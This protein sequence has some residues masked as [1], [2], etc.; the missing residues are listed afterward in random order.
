MKSMIGLAGALAA[1]TF[2]VPVLAQTA[3]WDTGSSRLHATRAQLE[4]AVRAAEQAG[5]QEA[6]LIRTRLQE[7]DFRVG[8]QI[9]LGVTGQQSLTGDFLVLEGPELVLPEIGTI[10]LAGLLR[11]ELQDALRAEISKFV[12]DPQVVARTNVRVA[13]FGQVGNP[14]YHVVP[15][16]ALLTDVI[17]TAGGPRGDANQRKISVRRSNQEILGGDNLQTAMVQGRTLDQLGVRAG[18]EI[19]V[20]GGSSAWTMIRNGLALASTVTFI[21]LRIF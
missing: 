12:R 17:M 18:D 16:D 11:S 3:S 9:I 7:G 14:G 4:D 20:P 1:L 8:D 13:V 2:S 21:L 5:S 6:A 10:S 15:S 19:Q